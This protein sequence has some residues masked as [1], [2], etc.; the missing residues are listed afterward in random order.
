VVTDPVKAKLQLPLGGRELFPRYRLV[1]FCGTPGAPALGKLH[2]RLPERAKEIE[3]VSKSYAAGRETLPIFELIAVVVQGAPGPDGKYRHR[4]AD[5]VVDEF[6][7]AAREAK[8]LLLLNVQ[9]GRSDFMTEVK[10]FEK[11]LREPDVSVALDPEWAIKDKQIPGQSYGQ[12]TGAVVNEVAEYLSKIVA[13]YDLPEKPLVFH[14]VNDYVFKDEAALQNYP[15]IVL[16]KSVDGLGPRIPKTITYN[17]LLRTSAPIV[18]P[19]FKLFFDEDTRAGA[20][21]MT[22]TQ[23]LALTPVP[24][25]VMYE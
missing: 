13:E 19:G 7:R 3:Q 23:V 18:H 12:T 9:P 24:E 6:L 17:H 8:A 10:V 22:P 2:N 11:Y 5:S 21:L 16:V 1:G 20:R 4:V 25:Y 14:Q 15:G